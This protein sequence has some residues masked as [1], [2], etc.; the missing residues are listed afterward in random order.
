MTRAQAPPPP[1]P[2]PP[3]TPA[4]PPPF[5]SA[6]SKSLPSF[7]K[8][9]K[10]TSLW[11][12]AA[13]PIRRLVRLHVPRKGERGEVSARGPHG[14][15][16]MRRRAL[17]STGRPVAPAPQ[18]PPR[19]GSNEGSRETSTGGFWEGDWGEDKQKDN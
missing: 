18:A 11:D 1:P 17:A 7:V 6:A 15:R 9:S 14:P 3:A 13:L 5:S 16:P 12:T 8:R 4:S 10:C 2:P 19:T